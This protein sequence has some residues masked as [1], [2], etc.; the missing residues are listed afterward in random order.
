MSTTYT[1]DVLI[2]SGYRSIKDGTGFNSY[3]PAPDERDR[4]IIKDGEVGDTLGLMEKVVWK[5][6]GDTR[7]IAKILRR[8]STLATCQAIWEFICHNIQYKLDKQGLEQLRRPARSWAERKTGVDCDCMSIFASSI[9]TNLQIPHSFRVTRYSAD[10]WQHVY[11]IVPIAGKEYCVIDAV[12][13]AFNHEKKY[14]DKMDYTMNLKGINVAVLSGISG[15]D[16]FDA[17]MGHSL[18]GLGELG[19]QQDLDQLYQNI[20]ATRN[21]VAKN[22]KLVTGVDDP[23][24]LLKMLDYAI[25]YWHTDK[26]DAALD[27]LA[28]NEAKLNLKNGVS[29]LDDIDDD[30]LGAAKKS[31]GFFTNLKKT[32]HAVGQKAGQAAKKAVKAMVRFNPLSVAARNGFL[33]ALKLNL[34]KMGT[35]LKWAYATNQQAAAKGISPAQVQKSKHALQKIEKL[36]AD[37][38]QGK[39]ESLQH[40]ILKGRAGN[41]NGFVEDQM[42]GYLGDPATA[43]F[44]AAATPVI[45]AAVKILKDSG[46]IG[47]NEKM[48]MS[49]LTADANA[50]PGSASLIAEINADSDS[51]NRSAGPGESASDEPG[52]S[53]SSK[54]TS[55]VPGSGGG[56]LS[57]IKNNPIPSAIGGGVIAFGIYQ[58]LKPKKKTAG[59]S[60]YR[61]NT[62]RKSKPKP[63][64]K[65]HHPKIKT[66]KLF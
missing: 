27:V 9:L 26:R 18:S 6:L 52:S 14:T 66:V 7:R 38:L 44:L 30:S 15:N 54:D 61:N 28:Q 12:V 49:T 39:R 19:S 56:I 1:N 36:F 22:P 10:T 50:D 47:K 40:A 64:A 42:L 3:F 20:L 25:E 17:I 24:A 34:G 21:T 58:L 37:K 41:L 29:G 55:D 35:K 2:S 45:I 8:P 33:A 23:Q 51:E 63:N 59:L 5:Y 16:H 43:T 65:T 60:G 48:D 31:K 32:V 53:A 46:L 11:V 62:K 57:M 13:S 4:I